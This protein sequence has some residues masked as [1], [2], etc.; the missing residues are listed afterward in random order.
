MSEEKKKDDTPQISDE[1][2]KDVAGGGKEWRDSMPMAW[3]N[4]KHVKWSDSGVDSLASEEDSSTETKR[5]G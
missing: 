5:E 2:L 4:T 3:D 1:E